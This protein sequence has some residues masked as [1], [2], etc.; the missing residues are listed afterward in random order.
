FF[1]VEQRCDEHDLVREVA[2]EELAVALFNTSAQIGERIGR[3]RIGAAVEVEHH[4]VRNLARNTRTRN[5]R[6][7]RAQCARRQFDGHRWLRRAVHDDAE[8]DAPHTSSGS[9]K[10][11]KERILVL[12]PTAMR[13]PGDGIIGK[14]RCCASPSTTLPSRAPSA[15][16][17]RKSRS[18]PRNRAPSVPSSNAISDCSIEVG[19]TISKPTT[20][21]PPART[22]VRTWP[23]SEVQVIAGVPAN[24]G[25]R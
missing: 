18:K 16:A 15:S 5:H 3:D 9:L 6:R 10:T 13:W 4:R 25:V 21:A 24:G 17:R 23:I 7:R 1:D 8:R 19:N 12:W 2:A 11:F 14:S 22:A 20:L